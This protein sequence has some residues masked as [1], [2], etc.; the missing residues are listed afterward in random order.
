MGMTSGDDMGIPLSVEGHVE[1]EAIG[2]DRFFRKYGIDPRKEMKK[3][4]DKY[5]E[6]TSG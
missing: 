6:I 1:Q 5:Q 3:L 4:W 2:E